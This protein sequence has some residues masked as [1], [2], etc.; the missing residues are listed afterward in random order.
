MRDATLTTAYKRRLVEAAR[1]LLNRAGRVGGRLSRHSSHQYLDRYL[2]KAVEDAHAK[3]ERLY[4]ITAGVLGVQRAWRISGSSLPG[5]WAALKSWR[6]LAPA[7][8]RLPMTWYTFQGFL[9]TCLAK[10]GAAQGHV[11]FLWWALMM[12]SWLSFVALLRPGELLAL[13]REDITLPMRGSEGEDS[14]GMVVVIRKPK[15]RRVYRTQ[16]VLVKQ[17]P[18]IEWMRWWVQGFRRHRKLFPL[19]RHQWAELFRKVLEALHLHEIGFT[20]SSMRAGG[21]THIFREQENLPSLQYMG[22]WAKASTLRHYLHMAF[23]TYT[24]M[25]FPDEAVQRLAL[26]H[27]HVSRLAAPPSLSLLELLRPCRDE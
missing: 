10:G 26:T 17:G 4:Y 15:T 19:E 21:A 9:M 18:L 27:R 8:S 11:R 7:R 16:F 1:D 14:P 22:R 5:T 6:A 13:K 24:S 25:Q 20:P 3:G 2:E 23:S 12:G